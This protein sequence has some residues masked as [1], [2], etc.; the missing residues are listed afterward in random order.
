MKRFFIFALIAVLALTVL[1]GCKPAVYKDGTYIAVSN[2]TDKGYMK[3][4]VTIAKDKITAVKLF[5]YNDLAVEKPEAYPWPEYHTA[6]TE[7][8]KRMI[9]KNSWDVEI[10]SKATGTSNQSKEAVKRAMEKA[11][12]KP[13]STAKN[14][15]GTFMAKSEPDAR[16]AWTIVWVTVAADKIT[17]VKIHGTRNVTETNAAG[18]SVTKTVRKDETYSWAEYH[19]ALV[20][21][22]KRFVAA[23]GPNVDAV[24]AATSTSTQAKEA[25]T[26]ALESAKR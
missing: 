12:V 26:R 21:L 14:F 10:V 25:V 13:A 11:L 1:A 6:L 4:E 8:P 5:G 15:D 17:D 23:N 18:E 19:T 20:E 24:T 7:L 22:P 3:A 9:A 16:G 2:A